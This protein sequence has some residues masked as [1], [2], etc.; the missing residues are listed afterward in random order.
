MSY[1]VRMKL[2]TGTEMYP[3]HNKLR[4]CGLDLTKKKITKRH[5]PLYK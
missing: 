4:F 5:S 3:Y 1:D 2:S